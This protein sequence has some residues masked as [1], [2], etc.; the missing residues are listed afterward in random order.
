M[1]SG[2]R[3]NHLSL[4]IIQRYGEVGS[5]FERNPIIGNAPQTARIPQLEIA[6]ES[7]DRSV[8][9]L[10]DHAV[11]LSS[12]VI[13]LVDNA[14]EFRPV[15]AH[16][17]FTAELQ[18][19]Q[20]LCAIFFADEKDIAVIGDQRIGS[21]GNDLITQTAAIGKQDLGIPRQCT[22]LVDR[23][24]T[25]QDGGAERKEC[26]GQQPLGRPHVYMRGV[27]GGGKDS[28]LRGEGEV[29]EDRLING[30]DGVASGIEVEISV[31]CLL[32]NKGYT[33]EKLYQPEVAESPNRA[34]FPDDPIFI[35]FGD[36]GNS[37]SAVDDNIRTLDNPVVITI[38]QRHGIVARRMF[39]TIRQCLII[40]LHTDI[41][42]VGADT[43]Y[44]SGIA[45]IDGSQLGVYTQQTGV[46][47][48]HVLIKI[49]HRILREGLFLQPGGAGGRQRHRS[50]Q[51]H[52]PL[53]RTYCIDFHGHNM[54]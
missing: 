51:R 10:P 52:Q 34:G 11:G 23:L 54:D 6:V 48:I 9:S 24:R 30:F 50:N 31:R 18:L 5:P 38:A 13:A 26:L 53:S 39:V 22:I 15:A 36:T 8:G 21:A 17:G 45:H 44:G 37:G 33:P 32:Q 16:V 14:E 19:P 1:L 40:G 29:V 42:L 35:R 47:F 20:R 12:T 4:D 2:C 49:A 27:R 46:Q 3:I 41:N 43:A 28:L 25:T 7:G